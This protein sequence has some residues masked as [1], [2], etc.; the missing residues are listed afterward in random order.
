LPICA[1]GRS[2]EWKVLTKG[3]V[4]ASEGEVAANPRSR[5]ARLRAI[6]RLK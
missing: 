2:A 3:A 5:S 4:Q 6:E 1:C